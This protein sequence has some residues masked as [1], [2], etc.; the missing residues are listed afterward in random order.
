MQTMH[1]D[2]EHRLMDSSIQNPMEEQELG[3]LEASQRIADEVDRR[4]ALLNDSQRFE[5][6]FGGKASEMSKY[7]Q[8]IFHC[9]ELTM[10]RDKKQAQGLKRQ[11]NKLLN[12]ISSPD[13]S[14]SES[15]ALHVQVLDT[16]YLSENHCVSY[17]KLVM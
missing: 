11:A 2:M 10:R 16:V 4:V 17:R 8:D 9:K 15:S 5:A 1:H 12:V 3:E 13:D 6:M 14:S 7:Y